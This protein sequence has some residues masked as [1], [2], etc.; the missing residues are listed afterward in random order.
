M[1]TSIGTEFVVKRLPDKR[2]S[3]YIDAVVAGSLEKR[4][5]TLDSLSADNEQQMNTKREAEGFKKK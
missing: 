1:T 3:A 5:H 4:K 2:W